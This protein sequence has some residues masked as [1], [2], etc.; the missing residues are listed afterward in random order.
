[1]SRKTNCLF[2]LDDLFKYAGLLTVQ[3]NKMIPSIGA[4]IRQTCL[5]LII[6]DLGFLSS[7]FLSCD[8]NLLYVRDPPALL[9]H[10][11]GI[12]GVGVTKTK[13]MCRWLVVP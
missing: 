3:Y 10:P 7:V 2:V 4:K 11:C 8:A 9:Y 13:L 12:W 5:L 1:M 6:E